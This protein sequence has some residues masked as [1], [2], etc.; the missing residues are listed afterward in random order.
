MR[1]KSP[2]TRFEV[3]AVSWTVDAGR[4]L[5]W[6]NADPPVFSATPRPQVPP[7]PTEETPA[8][9]IVLRDWRWDDEGWEMRCRDAREDHS[10]ARLKFKAYEDRVPRIQKN[11]KE[12][13]EETTA[14]LEAA[15]EQVD[16]FRM[17]IEEVEVLLGLRPDPNDD[18]FS[19]PLG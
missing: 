8:I 19:D 7:E 2:E 11:V 12:R 13:L 14:R 1:R 3:A 17:K 6:Q 5:C 10:F 16:E 18:G 4:R 15:T 9:A